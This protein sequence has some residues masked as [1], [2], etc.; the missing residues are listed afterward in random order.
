MTLLGVA[1]KE[2]M[3]TSDYG[4]ERKTN[5]QIQGERFGL[6][7][8]AL[9]LIAFSLFMNHGTYSLANT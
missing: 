7:R 6:P 2:G 4:K 5:R 3:G 8:I 1:K 9:Q